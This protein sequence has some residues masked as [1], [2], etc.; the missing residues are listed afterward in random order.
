MRTTTLQER[1]RAFIVD[2]EGALGDSLIGA[3]LFGSHA[4]GAATPESD[5]D[6]ACVVTETSLA[7]A[8]A[9]AHETLAQSELREDL[10][11]LSVE[12]YL[13]IKEQL[14]DGDPFARI[15]INHG[16]IL[17][18][19]NELL[20]HLQ[21]T[22]VPPSDVTECHLERKAQ[23]HFA[24]AMRAFHETLCQVQ[25]CAMAT[26]QRHA[27][28]QKLA[29]VE[30]DLSTLCDPHQLEQLVTNAGFDRQIVHAFVALVGAHKHARSANHDYP[31]VDL[32]TLL[33]R[34]HGA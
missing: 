15:V 20:R 16:R 9:I 24:E 27:I 25:L 5:V 12:S 21:S 13:R 33:Y 32:L 17:T 11:S 18:E 6:I 34:V 29:T 4:R 2:L 23:A 26:F 3:I 14:V 8:L 30:E 7:T 31:G 22:S 19:R 10:V 1:V 28:G